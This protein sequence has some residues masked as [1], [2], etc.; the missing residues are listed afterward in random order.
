MNGI[1]ARV[2]VLTEAGR[3]SDCAET[4]FTSQN[5]WDL[6][7]HLS[8]ETCV[9]GGQPLPDIG[10]FMEQ[11][12]QRWI[13]PCW[14][15]RQ[16][17]IAVEGG[18]RQVWIS[19]VLRM[20]TEVHKT[21]VPQACSVTVTSL[22][23]QVSAFHGDG[24][25]L[26][27]R[28]EGSVG[29]PADGSTGPVLWTLPDKVQPNFHT[30]TTQERQEEGF[31]DRGK[32]DT[33]GDEVDFLNP[34]S[35]TPFHLLQPDVKDIIFSDISDSSDMFTGELTPDEQFWSADLPDTL[36]P[37]MT[38]P[39]DYMA[40]MPVAGMAKKMQEQEDVSKQ[41][42]GL[43]PVKELPQF[44]PTNN[45]LPMK[46][47]KKEMGEGGGEEAPVRQDLEGRDM[48]MALEENIENK[49]HSSLSSL[50]QDQRAHNKEDLSLVASLAL[51]NKVNDALA[52]IGKDP[53][54][55]LTS[56]D[57]E[58]I[59]QQ[60]R[61][62]TDGRE[63]NSEQQPGPALYRLVQSQDQ[64]HHSV[65]RQNDTELGDNQTV[66]ETVA[67]SL[68]PP[69][70]T[71]DS[72]SKPRLPPPE[73]AILGGQPKPSANTNLTADN[74]S[75]SSNDTADK[76][77]S[78][79]TS[80]D[81]SQYG[82]AVVDSS[83]LTNVLS[84]ASLF[85]NGNT[86]TSQLRNMLA[87]SSLPINTS[88][89]NSGK[90]LLYPA[91]PL[92]LEASMKALSPEERQTLKGN[93]LQAEVLFQT[94]FDHLKKEMS[95]ALHIHV[96]P[97][98]KKIL[99]DIEPGIQRWGHTIAWT[100][101]KQVCKDA[102]RRTKTTGFSWQEW[103][104]WSPCTATCGPQSYQ[105]RHRTCQPLRECLG[106]NYDLR[107]C[108][109]QPQCQG[110][111]V[112]KDWAQWG[113]CSVTCG[114][115]GVQFR[116]RTCV[117]D[118]PILV[119][120]GS[121]AETITCTP[122]P[123]AP[124]NNTNTSIHQNPKD[125]HHPKK[126]PAH[127]H[128]RP[129]HRKTKKI[130]SDTTTTT[131]KPL[132]SPTST[133]KPHRRKRKRQ[134]ERR[135][136]TLPRRPRWPAKPPPNHLET[137]SVLD[138]VVDDLE[139]V[140]EVK[141]LD[142]RKLDMI[143]MQALDSSR[144]TQVTLA[145]EQPRPEDLADISW[146]VWGMWSECSVSC[147]KGT[148]FR[149]R[150]CIRRKEDTLDGQQVKTKLC[151]GESK[152]RRMCALLPCP[153]SV[154][155]PRTL[156]QLS[157]GRVGRLVCHHHLKGHVRH[158]YWITPGQDMVTNSSEDGKYLVQD[159]TLTINRAQK[160][161]LG[162]YYC[163]LVGFR[164][165]YAQK[166]NK[167]TEAQSE[168][169]YVGSCLENPCDNGGS[170][171]DVSN[172]LEPNA[173]I[174]AVP[175]HCTCAE[176]FFGKHCEQKSLVHQYTPDLK[177]MGVVLLSMIGLLF[178]TCTSLCIYYW[179]E[180]KRRGPVDLGPVMTRRRSEDQWRK[181]KSF[182]HKTDS[183]KQNRNL[184]LKMKAKIKKLRMHGDEERALKALGRLRRALRLK[185]KRFKI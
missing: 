124:V 132:T 118:D 123:C 28:E 50:L 14:N 60:Q 61:L 10:W 102:I 33:E 85:G 122:P 129:S 174:E 7:V 179:I 26:G 42:L 37:V 167:S 25:G 170:C 160:S 69:D 81:T 149:R 75:L 152:D 44:S 107:P 157:E 79:I 117:S 86:D 83:Q 142:R 137:L 139:G 56:A 168:K 47:V 148:E 36:N 158:M 114:A 8:L 184:V 106:S 183:R 11:P 12:E 57:T 59:L 127:S 185:F 177:I 95:E 3:A 96:R 64:S 140:Q 46:T 141:E 35:N 120:Q 100:M 17:Q 180:G 16:C 72:I 98:R 67:E 29:P 182:D 49:L 34:A 105:I 144:L 13:A 115:G 77:L 104:L 145:P 155:I 9:A 99:G 63:A 178:L 62:A 153:I 162:L 125:D 4:V 15:K 131:P 78:S 103:S 116:T 82:S 5:A 41:K 70:Q 133:R 181:M 18:S 51:E 6:G 31:L 76:N 39:D 173:H 121:G 93:V 169:K 88:V 128:A 134:P 175:Y 65:Q 45:L 58:A 1:V 55:A 156:A 73:V 66:V 24:R 92:P 126:K 87:G 176:G 166:V 138:S 89:Q 163:V 111:S 40:R 108:P 94:S 135:R 113:A 20:S 71:I 2:C 48:M 19:I 143:P 150:Q 165:I 164:N 30:R 91:G 109:N 84:I 22:T 146:S 154:A 172:N 74:V 43:S 159:N 27:C 110:P 54:S 171:E 80:T 161:D 147:D 68:P 136:K 130:H 90:V 38:F 119:C 53:S 52:S 101:V 97:S 23:G 151:P 32:R 21:L 112:W